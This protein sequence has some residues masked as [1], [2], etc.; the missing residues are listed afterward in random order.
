MAKITKATIKAFV[1]KN[2]EAMLIAHTSK[3]DG[4]IDGCRTESGE[5]KF[6]NLVDDNGHNLGIAGAW[7]VN[8]GGDFFTEFKTSTATGYE[9][10]NCCGCFKLVILN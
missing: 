9:I 10:S 2:Q 7:L 8:R 4:M 5:F 1:K 3:F 6:V